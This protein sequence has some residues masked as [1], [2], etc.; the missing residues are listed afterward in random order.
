MRKGNL[1][2]D[3]IIGSLAGYGLYKL[4]TNPIVQKNVKCGIQKVLKKTEVQ[5]ATVE[6]VSEE[7]ADINCRN[8]DAFVDVTPN[9]NI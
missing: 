6:Y 4:A 5:D 3:T 2:L 7:D 1:F 9:E 8:K